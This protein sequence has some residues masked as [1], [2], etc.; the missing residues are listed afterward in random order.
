MKENIKRRAIKSE[1][2][3]HTQNRDKLNS[4]EWN[5]IMNTEDKKNSN[6]KSGD[7]IRYKIK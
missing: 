7:Q 4:I 2:K 1:D 3:I 6:W 5:K